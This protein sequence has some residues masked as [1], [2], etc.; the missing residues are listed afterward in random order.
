MKNWVRFVKND[1]PVVAQAS[2]A[3]PA[4][5]SGDGAFECPQFP[6]FQIPHFSHFIGR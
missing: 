5:R 1:F 6:I 3:A 2:W 4:E